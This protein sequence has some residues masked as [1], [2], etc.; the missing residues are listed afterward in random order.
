MRFVFLSFATHELHPQYTSYNCG[1]R[2]SGSVRVFQEIF[3]SPC[4]QSK[5]PRNA[6]DGKGINIILFITT[7][8]LL[9]CF[10]NKP[11]LRFVFLSLHNAKKGF[12]NILNPFC[13]LFQMHKH[14]KNLIVGFKFIIA[15]CFFTKRSN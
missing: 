9:L 5:I 2:L 4:N 14:R 3:L 8:C 6:K 1:L 15:A 10:G 11:P 12:R 13:L 7:L